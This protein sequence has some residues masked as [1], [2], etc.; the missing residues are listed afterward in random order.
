MSGGWSTGWRVFALVPVGWPGLN[1]DRW[2]G[3]TGRLWN[4]E[5]AQGGPVVSRSAHDNPSRASEWSFDSKH[6]ASRGSEAQ[7]GARSVSRFWP[8]P[9][10][11]VGFG[12][13]RDG[14]H[15]GCGGGVAGRYG[16]WRFPN[17]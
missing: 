1:D 12:P 3:G 4:L 13:V 15:G 6:T 8:S 14:F 7:G 17:R 5:G 16:G 10:L 9:K 11:V 2:G